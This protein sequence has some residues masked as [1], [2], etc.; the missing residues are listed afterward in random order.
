[1]L[2]GLAKE[3]VNDDLKIDSSSS[4]NNPVEQPDSSSNEN[5]TTGI[6]KISGTKE[7]VEEE[8]KEQGEK[9]SRFGWFKK[10]K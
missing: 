6:E 3:S 10:K 1:V 7:K 9:K 8:K 4:F 2:P 5:S